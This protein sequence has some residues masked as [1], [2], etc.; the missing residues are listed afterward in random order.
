M[1]N[2]QDNQVI[3]QVK[4]SL[5]QCPFMPEPMS[6]DQS[7]ELLAYTIPVCAI[8]ICNTL[9]LIWIMGVRMISQV[10]V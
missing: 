5:L 3:Q 10:S 4:K 8:L 6:G 1:N 2:K 9:F 7:V